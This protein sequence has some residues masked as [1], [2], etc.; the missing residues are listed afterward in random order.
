MAVG[1]AYEIDIRE[2]RK[3]AAQ[4]HPKRALVKAL[5]KSGSTA[6]RDMRSET[7]KRVRRRKRIKA[8]AVKRAISLKRA[9]GSDIEGMSWAVT[10]HDRPMRLIDY[11]HRQTRKGV[12]VGI[13]KG[14]GRTLV[15]SAFIASMSS[16]HR[17]VFVRRGA[18]R[19]PI[20]EP[21]ASRV[22]D[23]IRHAGEVEG[24]HRRGRE[25]FQRAFARLLPMELE[26]VQ[27]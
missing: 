24:V 15:R 3:L 14:G 27:G 23:A 17:G 26:K 11:P 16:G 5:R 20:Y 18:S 7:S 9:K 8:K 6:L 19:L 25:S 1:V 21:A 2:L 13:N 12:S 10:I 22:I 4:K